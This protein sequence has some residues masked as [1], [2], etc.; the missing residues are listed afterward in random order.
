MPCV[1]VQ[2]YY[3]R[4]NVRSPYV[5]YGAGFIEFTRMKLVMDFVSHWH[6]FCWENGS[7][8]VRE[9]VLL[10]VTII[11]IPLLIYHELRKRLD[12]ARVTR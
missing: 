7:K 4:V 3:M 5:S 9:N 10:F 1:I 6:W 2:H 12:K 8:Y 11:C